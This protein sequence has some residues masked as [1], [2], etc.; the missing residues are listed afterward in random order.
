MVP[1]V[2]AES[3][4]APT[5]ECLDWMAII[6]KIN[7]IILQLNMF[8]RIPIYQRVTSTQLFYLLGQIVYISVSK[9]E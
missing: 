6:I 8:A 4:A 5:S 3:A 7:A 1:G 9:Q 2:S